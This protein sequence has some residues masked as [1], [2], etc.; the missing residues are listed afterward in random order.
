MKILLIDDHA[1]FRNGISLLLAELTPAPDVLE[2]GDCATG[3]ALLAQHA[4]IAL[5]LLDLEMPDVSGLEAL[6]EI[7]ARHPEMRVVVVSGHETVGNVITAIDAGA[8]GFIPKASTSPV[9]LA[10]LNLI[11]AGGIYL[12][13]SVLVTQIGIHDSAASSDVA[14]GTTTL[15]GLSERQMMVLQRLIRGMS[16]KD[17]CRDLDI[18]PSTVKSHVS[19]VFRA[20]NVATR[21]QAVV[22]AA[23]LGIRLE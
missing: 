16:N 10:A 9:M 19:A 8:L 14:S 11:L 4:D 2:A 20:L 12:P 18:S 23:R 17:I 7:R 6:A 5:V 13:P 15:P 3:C 1:L 22:A 21:T